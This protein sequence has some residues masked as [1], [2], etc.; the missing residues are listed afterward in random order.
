MSEAA[1]AP[2]KGRV[3]MFGNDVDTDAIIP[4][5]RCSTIDIGELGRY[6]MEGIDPT[7]AS[8]FRRGDIVGAGCNFGCGSS[9]ETAPLALLGAGVGA[10]VAASFARIFYR[11]AINVGLTLVES[12]SAVEG[13]GHGDSLQIDIAHGWLDNETTGQRYA[14]APYPALVREIIA[15]GG[16]VGYVRKRLGKPPLE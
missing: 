6:A 3:W 1:A 12:P 9:R 11:N 15:S 13:M 8:R 4:A 5:G 10:V 7:F 14:I 2:L 16:M